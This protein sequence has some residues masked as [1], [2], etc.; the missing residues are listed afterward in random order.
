MQLNAILVAGLCGFKLI[1]AV[2]CGYLR[3]LLRVIAVVCLLLRV[4]IDRVSPMVK[5]WIGCLNETT[6]QFLELAEDCRGEAESFHENP[7]WVGAYNP[8]T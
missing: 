1:S 8:Y 5:S 7:L 2:V 3:L 4:C 6:Y